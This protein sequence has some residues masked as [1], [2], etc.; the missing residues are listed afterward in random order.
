MQTPTVGVLIINDN[1]VLLVKHT[2]NSG[3]NRPIYGLPSGRLNEGETEI[4][5]AVR[6]LKEET[7][8]ETTTDDLKEFPGNFYLA[9]LKD[10]KLAAEREIEYSWRV[11][12]CENYSGEPSASE[13][14]IPEWTEIAK[15]DEKELIVNVKNAIEAGLNFRENKEIKRL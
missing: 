11:Y 3:Y 4:Q 7:G 15:L 2:E 14:T 8:L 6:E 12:Y 9:K 13:E 10:R 1:Q 5:A